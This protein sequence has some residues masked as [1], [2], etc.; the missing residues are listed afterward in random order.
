MGKKDRTISACKGIGIILMV[1]GHAGCPQPIHD[2]IY[3]FH[4]PLFFIITGFLFKT[5]YLV[6]PKTFLKRKIS[7]L[8]KPFLI[9]NLIGLNIIFLNDYVI[10]NMFNLNQYLSRLIKI[11]CFT[12]QYEIFGATW[13]LK[14][15]FVS[16]IVVFILLYIQKKR[17]LSIRFPIIISLLFL[18]IGYLIYTYR[19]I[20]IYDLQRELM[21]PILL[22]IGILLKKYQPIIPYSN[23]LW[24]TCAFLML[25]IASRFFTFDM[26]ASEIVNPIV[27]L[28]FS[29]IGFYFIYSISRKINKSKLIT[30]IGDNSLSILL[31]HQIGFYSLQIIRTG[32]LQH[33]HKLHDN[34][35]WIIYSIYAVFFS[36]LLNFIYNKIK[37][38]HETGNNISSV[39]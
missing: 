25:L 14:S 20:I 10:R 2:F 13:F 38:R 33:Y 39:R 28:I 37:N 35:Y 17:G 22:M 12:K 29:I 1:I 31:L 27:F 26:I 23:Y 15:L 4:M 24:P 30:Y 5:K 11:I 9:F 18:I 6:A 32:T 34:S 3:L 8:Y 16:N 36:L 7:T 21:I 19:G